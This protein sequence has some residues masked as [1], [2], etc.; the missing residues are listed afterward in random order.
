MHNYEPPI[1]L[2]QRIGELL[3]EPLDVTNISGL[4]FQ[5]AAIEVCQYELSHAVT[6]WR[7]KLVDARGRA[8]I[9]KDGQYTE[10]D[11]K[12]MLDAS[13]SVIER[14]ADFLQKLEYIVKQR[15]E[16]GIAVLM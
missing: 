14:D 11:R 7:Q 1:E 13:V 12:T 4:K 16:L 6:M 10:L 8:L 9:P 2:Y 5:L 3:R 15:L